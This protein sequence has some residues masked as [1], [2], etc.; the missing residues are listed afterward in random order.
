MIDVYLFAVQ[1]LNVKSITHKY[2][3]TGHTQN[4]GDSAHSLIE[5]N[6]KRLLKS[7][8][9]Y[10]PDT[11]ISAIRTAR[12]V[13]QPFHVHE[14]CY[15]DFYDIKQLQM[16]TGPIN[17]GAVKLADVKVMKVVRESPNSLFYKLSY[18]DTDFQEATVIK[19]KKRSSNSDVILTPVFTEK[20]GISE[21]K[22][23]DLMDL[24]HHNLIPKFYQP[25]YDS[26]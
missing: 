7:G 2:L 20:P 3:I 11:F 22:K 18:S 13:G 16:D 12:K 24:V 25:Y 19:R 15:D 8:P 10:T 5:R 17:M 9:M 1:F 21:R 14:M 26:L 23:K 4:E 6:V